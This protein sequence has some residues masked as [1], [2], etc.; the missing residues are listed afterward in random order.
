M[1]TETFYSRIYRNGHRVLFSPEPAVTIALFYCHRKIDH[2]IH[3]MRISNDGERPIGSH[4]DVV[5][6]R[7]K[8]N[9]F[10]CWHLNSFG[11]HRNILC[12][13]R[14]FVSVIYCRQFCVSNQH[15]CHKLCGAAGG[16]ARNQISAMNQFKF[17]T[18][19][20]KIQLW[21]RRRTKT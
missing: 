11:R 7:R 19:C 9:A 12:N 3:W 5:P 17:Q 16:L 8:C 2:F 15:Y 20:T 18:F 14:R 10:V 6:F 1:Q 13:R 21:Q 4:W